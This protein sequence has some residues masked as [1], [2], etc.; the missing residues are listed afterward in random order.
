MKLFSRIS[1]A[2][3]GRKYYGL[4]IENFSNDMLSSNIY[5][6]REDADRARK[7]MLRKTAVADIHIVCFRTHI[8]LDIV[9]DELH[10]HEM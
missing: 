6:T 8:P 9:E 4:L 1:N 5:R 2:L 7:W 10:K 3:L